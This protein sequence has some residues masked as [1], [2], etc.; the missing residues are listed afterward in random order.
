MLCTLCRCGNFRHVSP[1]G[2]QL[3]MNST[4]SAGF[5]LLLFNEKNVEFCPHVFSPNWYLVANGIWCWPFSRSIKAIYSRNL[6]SILIIHNF[7]A[8]STKSGRNPPSQYG[9]ARWMRNIFLIFSLKLARLRDAV[10]C[11]VNMLN[12]VSTALANFNW[13]DFLMFPCLCWTRC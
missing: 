9:T 6:L 10:P 8:S 11:F 13:A 2:C 12:V 5:S 7:Q 1:V 4:T 3:L